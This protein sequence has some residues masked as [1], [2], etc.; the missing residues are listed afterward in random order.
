MDP[1]PSA[2]EMSVTHV[3]LLLATTSYRATDFLDAAARLDIDV[4]VGSDHRQA[5]ADQIPHAGLQL[6]FRDVRASVQRIVELAGRQPLDAIVAAEDEGAIVAAAAAEALGLPHNAP[7]AVRLARYKDYMREALAVTGLP[8]PDFRILSIDQD[9]EVIARQ[10]RYPCVVKPV[11]L[12]ASR[13]VVRA[14]DPSGFVSAFRRVVGILETPDVAA[15]GGEAARRVLVEDFVPGI[16]VA[17]EGL[18]TD[19]TLK[20]LALFDKPDPLEGPYFE[21]TYYV[22]PSRLPDEVQERV[23]AV[24][25][26]TCRALGL[27]HGPVHAELRINDAG[28]WVIEIAPRSIGGLCSRALR[29][30]AGL[31]LEELILR[32]ALGQ[33]VEDIRPDSAA[34]GV[35]M[36]PIPGHGIL[37]GVRGKDWAELVQGVEGVT[38]SIPP[39]H[40]VVPLP[41]GHRYLGFVFARGDNPESVEAALREAHRRLEPVIEPVDD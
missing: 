35:L 22:T 36:L 40:E 12:A 10:L 9:P 27:R 8:T 2:R 20:V 1:G 13:G 33:D 23:V 28:V 6:D 38:I 5:L 14:D 30:G 3:L 32:H 34:A 29:F 19:G 11:F 16:E 37:R 4:T 41:E 24:A 17:L 39:G 31:S 25:D 21:E 7:H 18:L 15:R 26:R